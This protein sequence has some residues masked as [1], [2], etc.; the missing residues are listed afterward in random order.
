M[1]EA[2]RGIELPLVSVLM[3][4]PLK[5]PGAEMSCAALLKWNLLGYHHPKS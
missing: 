1:R 4:T 5:E 2:T 3:L